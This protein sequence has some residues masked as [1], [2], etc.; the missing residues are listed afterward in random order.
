MA[1]NYSRKNR[2]SNPGVDPSYDVYDEDPLVELARI[3]SEDG[4]YFNI[5]D[6]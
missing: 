6:R 1:D 5:A 2:L 3:V 4:G